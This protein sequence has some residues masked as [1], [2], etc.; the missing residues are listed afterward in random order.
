MKTKPFLLLL[1]L[2]FTILS[3]EQ[4]K[5]S[6]EAACGHEK[7]QALNDFADGNYIW[8]IFSGFGDDYLG[9]EEF[10]ELLH[11]NKIKTTEPGTSLS[12][13]PLP[14]DPYKY[15]YEK[16]MNQLIENKF[17]KKF[18]PSLRHTA[19]QKFASE[20]P[21][22]IFGYSQCD[23]TSRY[24][25]AV[26]YNLQYDKIEEAYFKR[27]PLPQNYI[28]KKTEAFFSGTSAT[29]ILMKNG[30]IKDLSVESTFEN[31]K[32]NIFEKQFNKQLKDFVLHTRWI[33]ARISGVPV[34]SYME[35]NIGYD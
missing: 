6:D 20:H 27:Y 13:I 30:E 12:C 29:F 5:N 34:D 21:N 18:I 35:A 32:N 16:E 25:D 1:P 19:K 24:P 9:E 31:K 3:C 33:P 28:K 4:N 14:D 22:E 15:C 2:L 8:T 11:Q 10:I 17:G 26:S 7:G 23:Q